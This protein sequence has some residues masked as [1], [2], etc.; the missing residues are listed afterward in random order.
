MPKVFSGN[1]NYTFDEISRSGRALKDP[2]VVDLHYEV[3]EYM[4]TYMVNF[5]E[6]TKL[7]CA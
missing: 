2:T 3:L 6:Q 4:H 5:W 1:G 7:M